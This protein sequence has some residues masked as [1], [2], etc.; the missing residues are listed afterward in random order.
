[1]QNPVQFLTHVLGSEGQTGAPYPWED[2]LAAVQEVTS[3]APTRE[4]EN[5]LLALLRFE[6][7]FRLTPTSGRP[8]RLSPEDMV[9]SLAIQALG[10][11][12]CA[13]H[14]AEIQR[15]ESTA[16]SPGLASVAR[17]TAQRLRQLPGPN[18]ATEPG[19][20]AADLCPQTRADG[21]R[22]PQAQRCCSKAPPDGP[23]SVRG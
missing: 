5:V 11:W 3:A 23:P 4:V 9:K 12:G 2:L 13:A 22:A 21:N 17:A 14:L 8:H 15:I 19:P 10:K 20:G 7:R 1:M 18:G 16:R 6:G